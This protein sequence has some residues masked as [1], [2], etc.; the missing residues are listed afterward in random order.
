MMSLHVYTVSLAMGQ[1]NRKQIQLRIRMPG[2][3]WVLT[4]G[5]PE[6]HPFPI[7]CTSDVPGG[8]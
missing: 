4:E 2:K 3:E 7:G 8:Q 6:K 5:K 1:T